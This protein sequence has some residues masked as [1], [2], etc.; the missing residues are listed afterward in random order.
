MTT[1][2]YLTC[3]RIS[4]GSFS[5][6]DLVFFSRTLDVS[7]ISVVINYDHAHSLE[8]YVHRIGRTARSD[9]KGSSYTFLTESNARQASELMGLMKAAGQT[10]PRELEEMARRGGSGFG[11]G[12]G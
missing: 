6:D 9:R 1:D 3:H 12:R 4:F 2:F 5:F 8:D 7:D 10:V 11:G